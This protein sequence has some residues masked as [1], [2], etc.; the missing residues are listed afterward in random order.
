MLFLIL[1]T[2]DG[3]CSLQEHYIDEKNRY[4]LVAV[5]HTS[6]LAIS[7]IHI[8]KGDFTSKSKTGPKLSSYIIQIKF[9]LAMMKSTSLQYIHIHPLPNSVLKTAG[10]QGAIVHACSL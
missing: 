8:G 5:S 2:L 9:H 1:Q 6:I 7:D 3:S 4:Q 10:S